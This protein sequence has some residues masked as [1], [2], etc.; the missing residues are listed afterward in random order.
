[1]PRVRSVTVDDLTSV[2]DRL[3]AFQGELEAVAELM[4]QRKLKELS[5]TG[6]G[7]YERAVSLL[8][9]FTAHAEFS[10]KTAPGRE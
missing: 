9:E 2:I 1:M 6:W 8:K 4:R 3:E 7:K 5:M 10:L